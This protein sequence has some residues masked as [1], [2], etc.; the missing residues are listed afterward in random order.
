MKLVGCPHCGHRHIVTSP[1]PAD[2]VV[3]L[4]CPSCQEFVVFYRNQILG[5]KRDILD[6]SEPGREKEQIADAL[7]AYLATDPPEGDAPIIGRDML[8]SSAQE[9]AEDEDFADEEPDDEDMAPEASGEAD[10]E[11]E[12]PAKR[13]TRPITSH[14]IVTFIES[15]LPRIDDPGYFKRTFQG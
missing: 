7:S 10:G 5:M 12:D 9:N 4:P 14:E 15:E 1:I 8:S 6:A 11:S 13:I 2:V 3:V